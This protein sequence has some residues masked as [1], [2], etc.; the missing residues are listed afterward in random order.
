MTTISFV[1]A[2]GCKGLPEA[3]RTFKKCLAP[4]LLT[5]AAAG[6]LVAS[7]IVLTPVVIVH[8]YQQTTNSPC[9]IG[10]S[11]CNQGTFVQPTLLDPNAGSFDELSPEYTVAYLLGFGYDNFFV[12]L[13]VNQS[14]VVQ[15]LNLFEML[16]ND[17]AVDTFSSSGTLV[18]PTV[19]GGNGNGYADYLLT[20]FTSLS[21][22]NSDDIIT[23]RAA[24]K[25]VNDGREQF[26]LIAAP[27][28]QDPPVDDAVP[29]P[30]S[31]ALVGAGLALVGW[32]K[33]HNRA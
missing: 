6:S 29:E 18:P 2:N 22:L 24:M 33:R 30:A 10:E 20:G 25:V 19:G 13:D 1:W 3:L 32:Y 23:F 26:F 4:A 12:G 15:Q 28:L 9:I 11:S 7:T 16:V 14:D 5:I 27:P 21:S 31:I 8:Q 17:V